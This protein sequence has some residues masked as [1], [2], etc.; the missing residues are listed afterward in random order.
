MP[1]LKSLELVAL[2]L[3]AFSETENVKQR[4]RRLPR[5]QAYPRRNPQ[6]D[7]LAKQFCKWYR[8]GDPD[9]FAAMYSQIKDYILRI[10]MGQLPRYDAGRVENAED[11]A[12]NTILEILECRDRG[13]GWSR[14]RGSQFRTW[15]WSI[16]RNQTV[17]HIRRKRYRER[18]ITDLGD[19]TYFG[20]ESCDWLEQAIPDHTVDDPV[21]S[22]VADERYALFQKHMHTL[23]LESKK[24]VAEILN[25]TPYDAIAEKLGCGKSTVSKRLNRLIHF[26]DGE[27][28]GATNYRAFPSTKTPL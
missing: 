27:L 7:L 18:S 5:S 15:L 6:E 19:D 11:I 24:L 21:E 23:P 16:T 17:N 20:D 13:T 28:R 3:L 9:D 14:S 26:F 25:R 1:R 22:L 4:S 8:T 10:I 12:Q 2:D